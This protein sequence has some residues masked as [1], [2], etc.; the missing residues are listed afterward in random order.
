M[1]HRA[2]RSG[3]RVVYLPIDSIVH[4]RRPEGLEMTSAVS[5]M[6]KRNSVYFLCK[7][8][9]RFDAWG[10]AL[11]SLFLLLARGAATL[12]IKRF[13]EYLRFSRKLALAYHRILFGYKLD[14]SFG[15][16]FAQ[17]Q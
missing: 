15:P 4:E 14:K 2:R 1:D 16:P 5:F 6:L 7:I 10:Y 3:W 8:G 9:K 13:A 17:W 11:L 12:N